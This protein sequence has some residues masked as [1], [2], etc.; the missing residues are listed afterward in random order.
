MERARRTDLVSFASQVLYNFWWG[1]RYKSPHSQVWAS[2]LTLKRSFKTCF[3]IFGR[4]L[5]ECHA[6]EA[7]AD[8]WTSFSSA[9]LNNAC[10]CFES[11]VFDMFD[12]LVSFYL[13]LGLPKE[14]TKDGLEIS[15]ATNHLGPFLLTTLLLGK[16]LTNVWLTS[17]S[18]LGASTAVNVSLF[19][20]PF[21]IC[22]NARLRRASWTSAPSTTRRDRWTSLIFMAKTSLAGWIKP[23][24]TLSCTLSSPLKS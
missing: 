6:P 17:M 3:Q 10:S 18:R 14:L 2:T 5:E 7:E 8:L 24:T 4:M 13:P 16:S 15:F 19:F 21:Q 22:W 23:T 12:W 1:S 9:L 11:G 20:L